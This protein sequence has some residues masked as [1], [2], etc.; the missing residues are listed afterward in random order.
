MPNFARGSRP[1]APTSP[2]GPP[3]GVRPLHPQMRAPPIV[4]TT[5]EKGQRIP[6]S[7]PDWLHHTPTNLS[8]EVSQMAETY[9]RVKFPSNILTID[10]C[11]DDSNFRVWYIPKKNHDYWKDYRWRDMKLYKEGIYAWHES[12]SAM[13]GFTMKALLDMSNVTWKKFSP[14]T[15]S[16]I[17]PGLYQRV[18]PD[19]REMMSY[20]T[21]RL[22]LEVRREN[23]HWYKLHPCPNLQEDRMNVDPE[24]F[25]CDVY[26]WVHNVRKLKPA[27]VA[28]IMKFIDHKKHCEDMPKLAL[29]NLMSLVSHQLT[30]FCRQGK[31]RD[32]DSEYRQILVN[33]GQTLTRPDGYDDIAYFPIACPVLADFVLHEPLL[34]A[35]AI[36]AS[37]KSRIDF[38]FVRENGISRFLVMAHQGHYNEKAEQMLSAEVGQWETLSREEAEKLL[39][40]HATSYECARKIMGPGGTMRPKDTRGY[41]HFASACDSTA[42]NQMDQLRQAN[43]Y[44][45]LNMKRV[46]EEYE[47]LRN[48]VDTITLTQNGKIV[49]EI[50]RHYLQY[51]LNREGQ[52]IKTEKSDLANWAPYLGEEPPIELTYFFSRNHYKASWVTLNG[53]VL[54]SIQTIQRNEEIALQRAKAVSVM[55]GR[56]QA[57]NDQYDRD[58]LQKPV[59][60]RA[61]S[62]LSWKLAQ[63]ERDFECHKNDLQ[64]M[65]NPA[66]IAASYKLMQGVMQTL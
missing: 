27:T 10:P 53:E 14:W 9:S 66:G 31:R 1:P 21:G 48:K 45:I 64:D 56:L 19:I 40:V 32:E 46:A 11:R 26:W 12:Y 30:N 43:A 13:N 65:S 60:A 50:T 37:P 20:P 55:A 58:H 44:L 61:E 5:G 15:E 33:N 62:G 25:A 54:Q 51:C 47:V 49:R 22:L 4:E 57:D 2:D 23:P 6:A 38:K 3:P 18:A 36:E 24:K 7:D 34:L 8:P 52:P 29:I 17:T 16:D 35:L 28:Y 41:L 42:L 39:V 59:Q 63:S